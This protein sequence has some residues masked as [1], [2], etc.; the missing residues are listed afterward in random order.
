[1][2]NKL[3]SFKQLWKSA[4]VSES[5]S[6]LVACGREFPR[7]SKAL[8]LPLPKAWLSCPNPADWKCTS[9]RAWV[10]F[11]CAFPIISGYRSAPLTWYPN[12]A[13]A[14]ACM[15]EPQA[16]SRM[17]S[18]CPFCASMDFS[19]VVIK[20]ISKASRL[21]QLTKWS[22]SSANFSYIL[23]SLLLN[24]C[25]AVWAVMRAALAYQLLF[26][27]CPADFAWLT[28]ALVDIEIILKIPAA[29]HPVNAGA[30]AANAFLQHAADAIQEH[31][32]L[33]LA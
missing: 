5:A 4:R 30:V 22:Y 20:G 1:M 29:I 27:Y 18:G 7:H 19:C 21:C 14:M 23:C 11:D 15:P 33:G 12:S 3:P 17:A 8:N 13:R 31:T 10:A 32:C 28:S 26:N 6:S 2:S 9:C 16:A 24:Q 25:L